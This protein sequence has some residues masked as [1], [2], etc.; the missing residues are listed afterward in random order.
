MMPVTELE[1]KDKGIFVRS[2]GGGLMPATVVNPLLLNDWDHGFLKCTVLP[3]TSVG[4]N[5]APKDI[6]RIELSKNGH[7]CSQ[8]QFVFS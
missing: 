3:K 4:V 2:C 7:I 6:D 1:T 8:A 5:C